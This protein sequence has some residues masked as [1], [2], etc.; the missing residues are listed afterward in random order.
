MKYL[1]GYCVENVPWGQGWGWGKEKRR[2]VEADRPVRRL[3]GFDGGG[4]V[5]VEIGRN[6]SY[7]G[8]EELLMGMTSTM[9]KA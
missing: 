3:V 1:F 7:V 9:L 2:K 8:G 4:E 6:G 5:A